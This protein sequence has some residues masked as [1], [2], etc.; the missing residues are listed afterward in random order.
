MLNVIESSPLL[1]VSVEKVKKYLRVEHEEDDS[2][3]K[4]LIEAAMSFVEQE[5]G[6]SLLTKIFKKVGRAQVTSEG[7]C[8]I[9]LR[10]PPLNK[11][12]SVREMLD[13]EVTRQV[14]R[15]VVEW[16]RRIPSVLM[17]S[18][19]KTF[20]VVYQCGFGDK[21]S[22]IPASIKQAILTLVSDMYERRDNCPLMNSAAKLLLAPYK[23]QDFI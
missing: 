10:Y 7:L 2:Q 15:F 19:S 4:L 16:E 8:R 12:L 18:S 6:Q 3:I 20:E 22:D 1:A 13:G 17:A 23:I 11:V 21:T 5:I 9:N 14:R